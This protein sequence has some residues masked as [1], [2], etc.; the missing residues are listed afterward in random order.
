[1]RCYQC[2]DWGHIAKFCRNNSQTSNGG[3][4]NQSFKRRGRKTDLFGTD[5]F[6][7]YQSAQYAEVNFDKDQPE[8]HRWDDESKTNTHFNDDGEEINNTQ[9]ESSDDE[10]TD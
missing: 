5:Q 4:V 6:D 9:F 1:M 3:K 10:N 2:N 7:K 8:N